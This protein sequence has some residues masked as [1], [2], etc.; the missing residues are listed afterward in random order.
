[1]DE[2]MSS[3]EKNETWSLT[4]LPTAKKALH[5]KSVFKI[6]K[7]PD[8]IKRYKV[9]VQD[10]KTISTS[11][12]SYF[13]LMKKQSPKMDEEIKDMAK[14]PHE[15]AVGN[16]MYVIVCTRPYI[17]HAVGVVSRFLSNPGRE[18]WEAVKWLL[19]YLKGTSKVVLYF[20]KKNLIFEGFPDANLGGCL[21]TRKSTMGYIFTLGGTAV[22]WM[23]RFQKSVALSTTEAEYMAKLLY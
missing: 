6:K 21:D 17:A 16:L 11:L 12:V 23:S 4:E 13:N 8:G 2:E 1:M 9:S 10:A 7:E 20:S 3:L 14:V 18:H 5:N 19:R 22:S 15:S